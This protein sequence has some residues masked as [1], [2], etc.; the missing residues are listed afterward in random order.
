MA[1]NEVGEKKTSR[2]NNSPTSPISFEC[3]N[4]NVDKTENVKIQDMH[5]ISY[6]V[7][8][9][10][11]YGKII[12]PITK[13]VAIK[14]TWVNKESFYERET[15]EIDA[16]KELKILSLLRKGNHK[17]LIMLLYFFRNIP[18]YGN[19]K[20]MS[21]IFEYM[22]CNLHQ[23]ITKSDNG[24]S[25]FDVK[26]YTW[27]LFRAQS[28]ME[29]LCVAHRDIKPQNILV[30]PESGLLKVGDFG[31]AKLMEKGCKSVSYNVTRYYRP[32]ELLLDSQKYSPRIDVWSCGCVVGE[33]LRGNILFKGI[34]TRDQLKIIYECLGNPTDEEIESMK[35]NKSEKEV[36]DTTKGLLEAICLGNLKKQENV[37][38]YRH[39]FSRDT[40][41]ELIRLLKRILVYNPEKRLSGVKLLKHKIF[42]ELFEEGAKRNGKPF[43]LLTKT[44][45]EDASEMD[46]K[47]LQRTVESATISLKLNTTDVNVEN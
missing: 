33:M 10:V 23:V 15:N 42:N 39:L 4:L 36:L 35:I 40:N 14:N 27:Q 22:P 32:P 41:R 38:P 5:L 37:N 25:V 19:K 13:Q 1:S 45:L 31:S 30:D 34:S 28:H 20:C 44:D 47:C 6:G 18:K 11:Y 17:N 7:F 8:S 29:Q 21:M 3:F 2:N 43:T 9:N 26:M 46:I 16:I 12:S 24:L